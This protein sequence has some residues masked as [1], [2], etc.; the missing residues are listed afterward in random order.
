MRF[1]FDSR[2]S[3]L[4]VDMC[5]RVYLPR[6]VSHLW[7]RCLVVDIKN[8]C[9]IW[10]MFKYLNVI[11][12]KS[13]NN[14]DGGNDDVDDDDDEDDDEDDDKAQILNLDGKYKLLNRKT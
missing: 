1:S 2:V 11:F 14:D 9:R 3:S 7:F 6:V 10:P 4:R 12:G 13:S 5:K 8:D